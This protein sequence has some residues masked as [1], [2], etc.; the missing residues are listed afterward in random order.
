MSSITI[1][2]IPE[3]LHQIL[4]QRAE[5]HNRSLNGEILHILKMAFHENARKVSMLDKSIR[6]FRESL[7]GPISTKLIDELIEDG[8]A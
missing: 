8:R 5:E 1:K 6:V 2:D 7:K 3:I 4:K